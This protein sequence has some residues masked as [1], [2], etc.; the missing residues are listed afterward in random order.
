[1]LSAQSLAILLKAISMVESGGNTHMIG[2]HG[3]LGEYQMT[4]A[5]VAKQGG[6]TAVEAAKDM[7]ERADALVRAGIAPL[8]FNLALARNA[9]VGAVI[10]GRAP[11]RSYQYAVRVRNLY[12]VLTHET[13]QA[14]KGHRRGQ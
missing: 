5:V 10:R 13:N 3:E 2:S 11:V 4:P 8:P 1:M 6:H 7:R 12:E 9:G 14:T